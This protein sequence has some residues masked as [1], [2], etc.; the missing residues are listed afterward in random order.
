MRQQDIIVQNMSS[1]Y[2]KQQK[3]NNS[4]LMKIKT[5]TTGDLPVHG[6]N[7]VYKSPDITLV[8]INSEGM[9]CLSGQNQEFNEEVFPW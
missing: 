7:L 5:A 4:I 1:T 6:G 2:R 9:L 8:E 3:T